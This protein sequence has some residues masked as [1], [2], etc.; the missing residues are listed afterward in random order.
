QGE[1]A[2]EDARGMGSSKLGAGAGQPTQR[3]DDPIQKQDSPPSAAQDN[4]P[5]STD[6]PAGSGQGHAPAAPQVP[7]TWGW[8]GEA[9]RNVYAP[10]NT[11][12][13][14]RAAFLAVDAGA[15][16]RGGRRGSLS[17]TKGGFGITA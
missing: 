14:D 9:T 10:R 3:G 12:E 1:A 8:G 13:M 4:G 6:C 2:P 16:A 7:V 17:Q 5:A 11:G 15:L